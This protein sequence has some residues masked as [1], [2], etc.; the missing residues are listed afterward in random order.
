MCAFLP[1]NIPIL[2]GMLISAPTTTNIIFWQ[3]FN[4]SFNA[5]L[6]YGNRNAS[7]PYTNKD[8]AFG[9]SAAVGSSVSMALILKKLFANVTKNV[10]GSKF[11]LVNSIIA[12][13]ASGTAG[14]L[15]TFCMRQVEMKNGIEAFRDE[16]LTEKLGISKACAKKAIIETASSRI[17]L[18]IACLVSPAV[19]FYGIE[20]LGKTP[21]GPRGKMMMEVCVFTFSLMFAL[22]ISIALFP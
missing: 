10:T 14:F 13:M 9:Y 21:K 17:L 18:S 19:I 12:A 20:K 5:G 16:Q 7:S 11:I 4:Q 8:L 22:P 6:N 2:F 3:W 15:N 1:V